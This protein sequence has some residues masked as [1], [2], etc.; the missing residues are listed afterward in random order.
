MPR[1]LPP[2]RAVACQTHHLL[3]KIVGS[4]IE[5]DRADALFEAILESRD[6]VHDERYTGGMQ[7]VRGIAER[8]QPVGETRERHGL[9][10]LEQGRMG[11]PPG[12]MKAT[13]LVFTRYAP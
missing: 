11:E 2:Q 6:P 5:E 12:N 4:G 8:L 10:L 3:S 7:F 1:Q 9:Q 13:D